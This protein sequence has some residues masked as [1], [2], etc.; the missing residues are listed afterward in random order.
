M[1]GQGI[2]DDAQADAVEAEEKAAVDQSIEMAR[3]AP[4]AVPESGL[5]HVFAG[6][7]VSAS[8]FVS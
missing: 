7:R 6:S 8:Q 4:L 3:A 1:I 5:D 2:I